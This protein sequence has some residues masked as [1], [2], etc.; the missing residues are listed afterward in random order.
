MGTVNNAKCLDCRHEFEFS[1]IGGFNFAI[2]NCNSC[3]AAKSI[4]WDE[5][6]EKEEHGV[7]K[8]GGAFTNSALPR[9]PVC[10]SLNIKDE[11]VKLYFD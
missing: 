7:C 8:C 9:C 3:S 1:K 6:K 2:V 11:G 5:K 10:Q 4:S